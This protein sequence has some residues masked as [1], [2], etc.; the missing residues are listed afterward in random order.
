MQCN[1]VIFVLPWTIVTMEKNFHF[2]QSVVQEEVVQLANY[3]IGTF[4]TISCFISEEIYLS[5]NS[6]TMNSK[7]A[8]LAWSQEKNWPWLERIARIMHLLCIIK[9]V[10]YRNVNRVFRCYNVEEE[11]QN[12]CWNWNDL[13][14]VNDKNHMLLNST[15]VRVELGVDGP[16]QLWFGHFFQCQVD[17]L[18]LEWQYCSVGMSNID[19]TLVSWLWLMATK[20]SKFY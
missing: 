4:P 3:N 18:L 17:L 20:T 14:F 6:L 15:T 11:G 16:V 10:V 7:N 19:Q 8:A 13:W 12:N 9:T 2:S 5:R 1:K